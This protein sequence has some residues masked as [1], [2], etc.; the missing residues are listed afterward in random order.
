M[1]LPVK[2][3]NGVASLIVNKTRKLTPR[4]LLNLQRTFDQYG[5]TARDKYLANLLGLYKEPLRIQRVK[6]SQ[7]ADKLANK[8]TNSVLAQFKKL[9]YCEDDANHRPTNWNIGKW[10]GVEIECFYPAQ[11]EC[12]DECNHDDDICCADPTPS[13]RVAHKKL[14][15]LI[16]KANIPRVSV[17]DDGSL[18]DEEGV[19]V[20]VT[21]L[22]N[23][24]HGFG[25]LERLCRVL[26]EAGCYVNKTCGLHVH[27]DARHLEPKGVKLIGKR[28]GR[29]LPILKWI[30][31]PSRH[32]NTYC[33]MA[34]SRFSRNA[35]RYYAINMTSF[36]EF[37][38]IEVRMHGGSTNAHKI[39]NWIE[40]LRFLASSRVP[41]QFTTF[42]DLIDLGTPEHLIEYAD[43]RITKLNPNAWS[44]LIP[45]PV[46]TSRPIIS[47]E[48]QR[49]L[50]IL[51]EIRNREEEEIRQTQEFLE[52]MHERRHV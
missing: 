39:Q 38:T 52:L 1:S 29:A 26:N 11:V 15:D 28:L 27:L 30:V 7:Y 3:E 37:K 17:K 4:Q 6:F 36:F 41:K 33:E 35:R 5:E 21:L 44:E 22:F 24:E 40:L 20:E 13:R 16:Q 51:A 48:R 12:T 42:Q 34:V 50:S 8:P 49:E 9:L 25:S 23:I 31:D 18:E 19:G 46:V 43:K 10:V 2:I 47:E 45:E 32:D 14:R